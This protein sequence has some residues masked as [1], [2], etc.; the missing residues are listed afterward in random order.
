[1]RPDTFPRL[2]IFDWDGT[3]MDS[4]HH[5][6]ACLHAAMDDLGLERLPAERVRGIIGRLQ[7]VWRK[8]G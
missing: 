1:M 3:L 2:V 4:E 8:G 7:V 5:I 6:V